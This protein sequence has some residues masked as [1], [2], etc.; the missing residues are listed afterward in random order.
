MEIIEAANG[1]TSRGDGIDG[2]FIEVELSAL[3]GRCKINGG[4]VRYNENEA[5]YCML[6]PTE[7]MQATSQ[8]RYLGKEEVV[9]VLEI[10]QGRVFLR[11]YHPCY[12]PKFREERL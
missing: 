9:P 6:H 4:Y 12:N 1:N 10:S 5:P 2:L 11:E 3:I 8:C 7:G